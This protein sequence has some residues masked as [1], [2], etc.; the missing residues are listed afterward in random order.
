MP[1]HSGDRPTRE[2]LLAAF[3]VQGQV[4]ET[5]RIVAD[6]LAQRQPGQVVSAL[7]HALLR[8]DA[9]FHWYQ[10]FE[11][12]VRQY[13]AWPEGSEEGIVILSALARFLA[14]HTP[15]R[16]ELSRVVD[17]ATRKRRV[18]PVALGAR[19]NQE[20]FAVAPDGKALYYGA[21][22]VEANVWK[23]TAR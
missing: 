7:G 11:A 14:A 8:E 23:V 19:V 12:G 10:V 1:S 4:D 17:I 22:L 2:T 15:T 9:E 13:D 3:D 6:V 20:S 16:R 21:Q 18:I 5:A